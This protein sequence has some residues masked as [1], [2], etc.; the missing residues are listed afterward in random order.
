MPVADFVAVDD[1]PSAFGLCLVHGGE[2]AA[3][4]EH[5]PVEGLAV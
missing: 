2:P 1:N 5:N 4:L 3:A